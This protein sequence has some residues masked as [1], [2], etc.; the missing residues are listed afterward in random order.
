MCLTTSVR[1]IA[2]FLHLS[3]LHLP[4]LEIA[5]KTLLYLELLGHRL[6]SENV[7]QEGELLPL[8]HHPTKQLP[9]LS[10][11]LPRFN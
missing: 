9:R 4:H 10:L 11:L 1:I 5:A 3:G 8:K 7:V 2:P 6:Y